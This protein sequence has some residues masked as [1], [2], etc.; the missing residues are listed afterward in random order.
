MRIL[1]KYLFATLVCM[2]FFVAAQAQSYR[3][4]SSSGANI[5][6]GPGTDQPVI[7]KIPQGSNVK[8][9][10]RTNS[11]WVKVSYSGQTG[12]VASELVTEDK[13]QN[14][15]N[16][17]G[18]SNARNASSNSGSKGRNNSSSNRSNSSSS[19]KNMG[20]GLRFGDPAGITFKK[21]SGNTAWEITLGRSYRWG[22]RYDDRFYR[23]DG[24]DNRKLYD[25]KG[26]HAGP[27]TALQ[28]HWLKH[29]NITG[30]NRLQ[31]YYGV[32][33][34]VRFTNVHY[35]YKYDDREYYESFTDLD[36]GVDGV[37]GLEYTFSEV[38]FSIFL[39][40]NAFVEVFDAP[41]WIHGQS[42][43]GVRYNF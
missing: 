24:F 41:G 5:R 18:N 4:S 10:E 15:N 36:L 25:Y 23:Y 2:L 19:A 26:H 7:A 6:K 8:L 13:G 12:Y 16:N 39:D 32:G 20:I 3:I 33:P 11:K 34:Q 37:I 1:Y 42:G 27:T 30:A 38:P 17:G 9:I 28:V 29:H 14:R 21:Y 40:A 31:F 43:I 22:Y 35:R